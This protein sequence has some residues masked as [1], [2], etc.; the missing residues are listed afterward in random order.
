MD[1][2][3]KR[4]MLFTHTYIMGGRSDAIC[5]PSR[6]MLLSGRG[7]F[8]I[9]RNGEA[10][11]QEHL[12]FPEVFR[13]AGYET[14]G[15][16]KWHN[17]RTAFARCFT[18]GG[19]IFFG[20]MTDHWNVP[21]YRFDPSGKYSATT[22]VILSPLISNRIFHKSYDHIVD[23][24]HS[25]EL[26]SD[27]VIGFLE[28][29]SSPQPFLAYVSFMAPHDPRSMPEQYRRMYN[30]ES[31]PLPKNFLPQHPFDNGE[32]EVRDERLAR[33][34]RTRKAVRRHTAEY[35]AMITHLDAQIGRI[36]EALEKT[37]KAGNTYIVFTSD[38]GLALGRHGLMGKQNLYE[39]SLRVP[40]IICGPDLPQGEKRDA[41]CSLHD[42][43]PTLCE[44][45][46]LTVPETVLAKSLIPA[47]ENKSQRGRESLLFAYKHLQRAVRTER[48]KL[49]LYNVRGQRHTQLFDL[50][51][52][53]EEI[54]NLAKKPSMKEK[55]KELTRLMKTLMK[56]AG[57]PVNLGS[58]TWRKIG[59]P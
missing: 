34:P 25:S 40:L 18:Q 3:L 42:V 1:S 44:L 46:G 23:G 28:N 22:P 56:E 14:F 29:Y 10:I 43:Y 7:L 57:D 15:T 19:E 20:G 27:A 13:K 48:W 4:G 55:I 35:Y 2:L 16:G 50:K 11:P 24:K 5:M 8:R 21:V 54:N 9:D 36:L 47:I 51:E 53:P 49:I 52:D 45:A 31:L 6:A 26:F 41:L 33:F 58:Q 39:H 30:P 17:G 32:L 37:G 38:N 59:I 12:M